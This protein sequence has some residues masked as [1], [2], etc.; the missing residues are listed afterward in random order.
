MPLRGYFTLYLASASKVNN[1]SKD[2]KELKLI[3]STG[4]LFHAGENRSINK[5]CCPVED[6]K[7]RLHTDK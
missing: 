3:A 2:V 7:G 1:V 6:F 4:K 5:K